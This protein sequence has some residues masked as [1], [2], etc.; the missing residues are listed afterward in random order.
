MKFLVFVEG[1]TEKRVVPELLRR[2]LGA[3]DLNQNVGV[4]PVAFRGNADYVREA[5][6]KASVRLDG[7]DGKEIIAILGLLDA[8]RLPEGYGQG[9][10]VSEQC[11]FAKS[12][13]E[14]QVEKEV[15]TGR[16]H[17]FFA[18]HE[19]E[20]WLLSSPSVFP[21]AVAER[22][23]SQRL[24]NNP[25]SVNSDKPPA[26]RISDAYRAAL[27]RG[28]KKTTDGPELF[29]KLDPATVSA[30]CPHLDALFVKMLELARKAESQ[31]KKQ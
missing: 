20:A 15:G 28:Y 22:L 8:L 7:R 21:K 25:E 16:F 30:K 29:K 11:N 12:R 27:R 17:Q 18:V 3:Q 4:H 13:I 31:E 5:P 19:I 23:G 26:E 9:H 14:G 6:K 2:W 1:E 24:Q 10:S